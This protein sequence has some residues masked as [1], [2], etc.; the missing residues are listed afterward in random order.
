M[1]ENILLMLR[2]NIRLIL[3]AVVVLFLLVILITFFLSRQ[4]GTTIKVADESFRVKVAKT[5]KEKQ[6]GLSDTKKLGE[7]NGMLF[8]FDTPD[9]YSFWMREMDFPIDIIYIKDTEVVDVIENVPAPTT[10]DSDLPVY[11]PNTE[12]N[13]VLELNS[14][15]AK[16]YNIKKGTIVEISNL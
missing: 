13:R 16:K 1:K 11:Q 3:G 12:A 15:S 6:I 7:K 9:K 4:T 8:V 2:E 5:D 14:G 10:S